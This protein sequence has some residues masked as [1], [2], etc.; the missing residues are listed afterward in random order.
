MDPETKKVIEEA[1]DQAAAKAAD[2]A[3]EQ[4]VEAIKPYFNEKVEEVK[5]HMDMRAEELEKEIAG[6]AD[7]VQRDDE[8]MEEHEK[9]ISRL[10][11]HAGLPALEPAVE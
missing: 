9:R 2:R 1:A 4:A 7:L 10:E 5:R 3:S 6:V 11:D 8:K